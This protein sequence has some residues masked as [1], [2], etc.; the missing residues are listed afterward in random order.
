MIERRG[1]GQAAHACP[2]GA[3]TVELDRR[4]IGVAGAQIAV[5]D[6][7]MRGSPFDR[8]IEVGE[9]VGGCG[10]RHSEG[11]GEGDDEGRHAR[12]VDRQFDRHVY[13]PGCAA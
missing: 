1:A 7:V 3:Q 13:S 4:E 12:K 10:G 5:G 8:S 11:Q 9:V 2:G 6:A